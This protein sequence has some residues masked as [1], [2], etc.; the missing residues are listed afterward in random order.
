MTRA[1]KELFLNFYNLPSR[2]LREIPSELVEFAGERAL[3]DEE[4]YIEY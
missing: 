4:R 1:K 2:F 3:E